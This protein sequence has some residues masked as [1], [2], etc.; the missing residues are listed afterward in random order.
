MNTS[1]ELNFVKE[2]AEATG[3][4]LDPVYRY[5]FDPRCILPK[6][7]FGSLRT[8]VCFFSHKQKAIHCAS[9]EYLVHQLGSF[10]HLIIVGLAV[11]INYTIL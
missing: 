1:E 2:V 4:V 11:L 7:S 5:L 10:L 3:V 8:P 9:H 6:C